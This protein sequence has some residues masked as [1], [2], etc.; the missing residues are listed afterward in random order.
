MEKRISCSLCHDRRV[1]G[2]MAV[3][4]TVTYRWAHGGALVGRGGI[5]TGSARTRLGGCV[6]DERI[7][8]DDALGLSAA[9]VGVVWNLG[10]A[11][12]SVSGMDGK[13]GEEDIGCTIVRR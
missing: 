2:S 13:E 6:P 4:A 7:A 11:E 12:R 8:A 5:E 3:K 1:Q 9:G 10:G